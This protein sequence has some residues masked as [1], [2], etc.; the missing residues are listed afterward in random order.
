MKTLAVFGGKTARACKAKIIS[1]DS[2]GRMSEKSPT[3]RQLGGTN[4]TRI[5][6]YSDRSQ[7]RE[8]VH[9]AIGS[10]LG[11]NQPPVEFVDFAGHNALVEAIRRKEIDLC[12]LDAEAAP[13]GGIGLCFEL[14]HEFDKCPPVL[15]LVQ[16]R[17]DAWLSTWCD[18]DAVYPLPVDPMDF[19][20]A[21]R[22]LQ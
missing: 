16:R 3:D 13:L 15:L 1:S 19:Q 10:T 11:P 5:A 7:T 21:V 22:R 20:D 17:D 4:A 12:I 9:A 6:V 8:E 18:A 2:I 14:K